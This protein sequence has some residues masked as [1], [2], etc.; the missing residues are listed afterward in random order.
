VLLCLARTASSLWCGWGRSTLAKI[1]KGTKRSDIWFGSDS[2]NS[3]NGMKGNDEISGLGGDDTLYGGAGDDD[4]Y[5]GLGND[6]IYGDGGTD[7]IWG[8]I[9]DDYLTGGKGTDFFQFVANGE[10]GFGSDSDTITD[11]QAKGT[12]TDVLVPTAHF[13]LNLDTFDEIMDAT[14]MVGEDA[15]LDFGY[16]D[17]IVLLGVDKSDLSTDNFILV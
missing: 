7:Y 14:Y 3:Y 8:D 4:L 12:G 6:R 9:G 15:W 16:G 5:R 17:V 2:N 11:F 10:F 1:E 13:T